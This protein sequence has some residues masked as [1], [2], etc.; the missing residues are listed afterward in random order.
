MPL[1]VVLPPNDTTPSASKQRSDQ[2]KAT[3]RLRIEKQEITEEEE[4]DV[5]NEIIEDSEADDDKDSEAD[6]EKDTEAD[7]VDKDP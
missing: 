5:T 1:R 6:D 7:N 4:E 2:R 3:K